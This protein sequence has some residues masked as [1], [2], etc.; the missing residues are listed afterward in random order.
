MA[1]G[2][3]QPLTEM[4]T[5][6]NF[7]AMKADV[8]LGSQTYHLHFPA[9][10]ISG[11]LNLLEHSESVQASTGVALHLHLTL[12]FFISAPYNEIIRIT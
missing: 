4:S 3:T 7:G 6:N 5:G 10:F 1:L 9:M 2:S 8:A 12:P 11:S